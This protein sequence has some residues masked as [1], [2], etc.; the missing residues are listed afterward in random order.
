MRAGRFLEAEK[1]TSLLVDPGLAVNRVPIVLHLL[2]DD[3]TWA[4]GA[5]GG[6]SPDNPDP[7]VARVAISKNREDGGCGGSQHI[8]GNGLNPVT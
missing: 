4:K 7:S 1:G 6:F 5:K 2:L 3:A 8:G